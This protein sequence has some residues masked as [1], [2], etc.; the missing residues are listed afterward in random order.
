MVTSQ[1]PKLWPRV[2]FPLVPNNFSSR[3]DKSYFTFLTLT[4]NWLP[5]FHPFS[6]NLIS[7]LRTVLKTLWYFLNL[8]LCCPL[9]KLRN[10]LSIVV[11]F[12]HAWV[13]QWVFK[14]FSRRGFSGCT[15]TE[16]WLTISNWYHFTKKLKGWVFIV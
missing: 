3:M 10:F 2:R 1:P 16:S 14:Y 5:Q 11:Q 7:L 6:S 12:H 8:M 15:W 9:L 4:I 13:N